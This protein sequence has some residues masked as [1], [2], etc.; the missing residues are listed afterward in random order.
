M[1][2]LCITDHVHMTSQP[3]NTPTAPRK[4]MFL[5]E[6][7]SL[8]H[9]S[10]A[11]MLHHVVS[12]PYS[13]NNRTRLCKNF[14]KKMAAIS[15]SKQLVIV[16][17]PDD[18]YYQKSI[19]HIENFVREMGEK[20]SGL[21]DLLVLYPRSFDKQFKKRSSKPLFFINDKTLRIAV[22][23]SLDLWIRDYGPVPSPRDPVKF[24]YRPNYLKSKDAKYIDSEFSQ[25]LG[26]LDVSVTKSDVVLDGGNV[27]DNNKNKAVIS[28]R[29]LTDNKSK[30]KSALK[31]EL[32]NLLHSKVAFIP[33]PE[34]T[35]GHSDGIV[36]FIEDDVL[37]I[38]DYNDSEY[39]DAVEKAVKCE[40]P[41]LETVRLPCPSG[42][43]RG[44]SGNSK[45]KGF[46]TAV[47]S[48]VNALVTNRAVYVPQFGNALCDAKALEIIKSLTSKTVVGIDTSKLSHMGGS[49]R[50]MSWQIESSHFVAQA[51]YKCCS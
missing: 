42:V 8:A 40:F 44:A 49:V 45:E 11:A 17:L 31:N 47:G 24:I 15:A 35:T 39:Y 9:V 18:P 12:R 37:L 50:C 19:S 21:D 10:T 23:E 46:T 16:S 13:D 36:S 5:S 33:D 7:N 48:Y 20:T 32:E 6:I 25:F 34:D 51:L 26:K 22:D 27:V 14:C 2:H 43:P 41:D 28:E 4:L 38:G 29:V 1:R 3:L 30:S